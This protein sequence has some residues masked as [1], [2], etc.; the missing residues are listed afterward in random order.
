ML[1]LEIFIY[2]IF[3]YCDGGWRHSR[4]TPKGRGPTYGPPK[5]KPK[6]NL[7]Y[8]NEQNFDKGS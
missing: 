7:G 2:C 8:G 5:K 1:F 3:I 4:S 6:K